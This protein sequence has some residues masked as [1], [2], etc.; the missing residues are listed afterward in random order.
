MSFSIT[1]T[2]NIRKH[3]TNNSTAKEVHMFPK[4][5]RFLSPNPEYPS[6]HQG[7]PM[8][9]TPTTVSSPIVSLPLVME[10]NQTSPKP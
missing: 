1:P 8:L 7:V 10:T 2:E 9:F 3:Q 5:P 6:I 4:T